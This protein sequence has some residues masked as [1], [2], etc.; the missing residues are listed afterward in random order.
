MRIRRKKEKK[1]KVQFV[2][3]EILRQMAEMIPTH[4]SQISDGKKMGGR[5]FSP[6]VG[7]SLACSTTLGS[8]S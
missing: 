2:E 6:G 5:F 4:I 1:K 8:R 3:E 7:S